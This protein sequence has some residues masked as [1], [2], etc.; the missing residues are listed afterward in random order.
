[1]EGAVNFV[2]GNIVIS[3]PKW[4]TKSKIHWGLGIRT[5]PVIETPTS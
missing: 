2:C 5:S 3:A 4:G 1:M